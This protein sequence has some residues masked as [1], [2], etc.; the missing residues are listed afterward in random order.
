MYKNVKRGL[1][2]FVLSEEDSRFHIL[3]LYKSYPGSHSFAQL[4]INSFHY[5]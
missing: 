5:A 4:G 1:L 3:C 2:K